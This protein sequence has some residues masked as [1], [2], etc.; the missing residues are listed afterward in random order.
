MT[1]PAVME[2]PV[3]LGGG[4]TLSRTMAHADAEAAYAIVD[5]ERVRLRR[6]LPWVDDTT[7]VDTERRFLLGLEAANLAG[8]GV[9]VTIRRDGELAGLAGLRLDAL[10]HTAD[11][12][13]WLGEQ[14]TGR[15]VVTRAVSALVDCAFGPLELHRFQLS[16]ASGN[17][18]SRAVAVRLGMVHEGT[19]REAEPVGGRFLDLEVYS[20]LASEWHAGR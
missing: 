9:H 1:A 5:A 13:Y 19:L 14:H 18:R 4:V 15:G 11:V 7:D 17:A 12:G 3:D 16:A 20:L 6:W 2:R 10:R 8:T